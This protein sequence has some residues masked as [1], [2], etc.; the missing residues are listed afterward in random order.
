MGLDTRPGVR[1]RTITW[2]SGR[3]V[4]IARRPAAAGSPA[5]FAAGLTGGP[6]SIAPAVRAGGRAK[7]VHR[8]EVACLIL[9]RVAGRGSR[10]RMTVTPGVLAALMPAPEQ[11]MTA[12]PGRFV[13]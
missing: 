8:G 13:R 11:L 2:L 10:G 9:P 7:P 12:R 4:F 5:G 1:H 6:P 3:G